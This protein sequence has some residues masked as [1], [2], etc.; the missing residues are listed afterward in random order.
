[1]LCTDSFGKRIV[2]KP[3][4]TRARVLVTTVVLG[5]LWIVP[6]SFLDRELPSSEVAMAMSWWQCE[7]RSGHGQQEYDGFHSDSSS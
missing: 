4:P 7:N 5:M 1:M 3:S 6:L 2:R